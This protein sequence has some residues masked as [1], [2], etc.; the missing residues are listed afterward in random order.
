MNQPKS[1]NDRYPLGTRVVV[2]TAFRM[3]E[4]PGQGRFVADGHEGE[5][6]VV[7]ETSGPDLGIARTRHADYAQ[8]YIHVQRIEGSPESGWR[9]S[10]GKVLRSYT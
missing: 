8:V 6:F 7:E 2:L 9:A 10:Y 3:G 1:L 4:R 5:W